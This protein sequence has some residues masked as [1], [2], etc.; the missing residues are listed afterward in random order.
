MARAPERTAVLVIRVWLEEENEARPLR[1][2][3]TSR[4]DVSA[5]RPEETTV[6]ASEREIL[7]AVRAWIR[8]V[9]ADRP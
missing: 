9:T 4:P 6:A 2:R 5:R 1:A 3:I 8:Q 7:G